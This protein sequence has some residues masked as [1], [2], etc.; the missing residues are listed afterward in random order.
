MKYNRQEEESELK[1]V[2][3]S[4]IAHRYPERSK[5]SRL[6]SQMSR[7]RHRSPQQVK[8]VRLIIDWL[9]IGNGSVPAC[10]VLEAGRQMGI[11]TRTVYTAKKAMGL[12]WSRNIGGRWHWVSDQPLP[13]RPYTLSQEEEHTT[14]LEE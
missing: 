6:W 5:L 2:P 3:L 4:Q 8:A 9:C 11:S 10:E 7:G 13:C 1:I 14:P 12:V